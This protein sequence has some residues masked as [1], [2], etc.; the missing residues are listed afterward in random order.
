MILEAFLIKTFI[1]TEPLVHITSCYKSCGLNPWSSILI[2]E[3]MLFHRRTVEVNGESYD[4]CL[5]STRFNV[6]FSQQ[7]GTL[8]ANITT[9][10]QF[11]RYDRRR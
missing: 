10:F 1:L 6:A 5:H 3:A 11:A 8:N 2:I 4:D 9:V 7:F